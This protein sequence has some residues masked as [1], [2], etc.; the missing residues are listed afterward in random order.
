MNKTI[1]IILFL[2]INN[3]IYCQ[4][5]TKNLI[6]T[7]KTTGDSHSIEN[8]YWIIPI[9][10]I[11]IIE[12]TFSIYPIYLDVFTKDDFD[13]CLNNTPID[14]FTSTVKTN[15]NLNEKFK[16]NI[17]QFLDEI[18]KK[19]IL[20]QTISKKIKFPSKGKLNIKIFVS[21]VTGNFNFCQIN[22]DMS[23][24]IKYKGK[25]VLPISNFVKNN[26]FLKNEDIQ[27]FLFQTDFSLMNYFNKIW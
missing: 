6:I 16:K 1:L 2:F 17:T 4:S 7:Y 9:K 11:D 3:L 15:Y 12:D 5:E 14:V 20:I 18:N 24:R 8:Q 26:N 19:S 13:N 22:E 25:I 23:K 27:Q 21:F 10:S